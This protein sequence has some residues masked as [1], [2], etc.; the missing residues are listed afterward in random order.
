MRDKT[1]LRF[2]NFRHLDLNVSLSQSLYRK[3][4]ANDRCH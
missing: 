2:S 3:R 4:N 1:L